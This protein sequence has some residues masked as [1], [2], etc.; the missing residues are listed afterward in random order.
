ME[1]LNAIKNQ[2]FK[3]KNER[4]FEVLA[5]KIFHFQSKANKVYQS[6][7]Q[8]LKIDASQIKHINRIPF[9]PIAFFKSHQIISS[10]K[11]PEEIFISSG[12]AGSLQSRHFVT[13]I[14][15]YYDSFLKGFSQFY[16]DV[17]E[18]CLLALLPSYLEQGG[19]SLVFMVKE[20]IGK[21][22]QPESGFYLNNH[23][24]LVELIHSEKLKNKKIMLI[25]V[26]FALLNL[27]EKYQ[28]SHPNLIVME[29]GGM[30]GRRKELIREELHTRL[31]SAF[32]VDTIHS[33][34][35]MTELLSQAYSSGKG[36]FKTPPWMKVLIRDAN[37]PFSFV[38]NGRSGGI[39]VIDLANLNSCSFIMTQDLG[40]M[41]KGNS[42]EVQG[43]FDTSDIRGCNLL[44]D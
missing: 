17:S 36:I 44:V 35:G 19:S 16:G 37:D 34:Y 10:T 24:E 25:G 43:R 30:K 3:I 20:L 22:K 11:A 23:E 6:Y 4:E 40:R 41:V 39:N 28:I 32:S 21:S 13:D 8:N 27:I 15:I 26:S 29:T 1:D 2:I 38:E 33:E 31:T 7:L 5:L 14:G 9:L 18:Y 12:T 42:F